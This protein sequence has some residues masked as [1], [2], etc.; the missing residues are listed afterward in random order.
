MNL[1]LANPIV[2][3]LVTI[4]LLSSPAM[5]Q[6]LGG[7]DDAVVASID[8]AVAAATAQMLADIELRGI[9]I[10]V[11]PIDGDRDDSRM[12]DRLGHELI[13]RLGA[14]RV[15]TWQS[16][17]LAESLGH[18]IDRERLCELTDDEREII[19][20]VLEAD[21]I[22][23]GSVRR[24]GLDDTGLRGRTEI[25]LSI[26]FVE[27]G[28]VAGSGWQSAVVSLDPETV[29][30]SIV[31]KPSFWVL[32]GITTVLAAVVTVAWSIIGSPWRRRADLAT[33][34]REIVR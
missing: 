9:S 10:A 4:A 30:L 16:E 7:S 25:S 23:C 6:R 27:T 11:L 1:A 15:R 18:P 8:Q 33:K 2:L 21:A 13:T 17:D 32:V 26:I 34:P 24:V 12:T 3:G 22:V 19:G 5:S 14:T 20:D 28:E 31:S 29:T